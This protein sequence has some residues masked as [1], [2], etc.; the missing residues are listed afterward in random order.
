MVTTQSWSDIA[1][2]FVRV[3]LLLVLGAEVPLPGRHHS[4]DGSLSST[5]HSDL[6]EPNG[7]LMGIV[8][9]W[10]TLQYP[11][12]TTA[13]VQDCSRILSLSAVSLHICRLFQSPPP[14]D[15]LTSW[16]LPCIVVDCVLVLKE[17]M[18][19]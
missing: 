16:G 12:N 18:I 17:Y 5:C 13:L 14:V 3:F 8:S 10:T 6:T 11:A 15:P 19:Y 2:V 7:L 4:V 1:N 9:T